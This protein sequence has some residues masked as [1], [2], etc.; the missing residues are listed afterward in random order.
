[1][2]IRAKTNPERT[3]VRSLKNR[4]QKKRTQNA[5]SGKQPLY[6]RTQNAITGIKEAER[7]ER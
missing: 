6:F 5:I 2:N 1:M 4:L 7:E 3:F